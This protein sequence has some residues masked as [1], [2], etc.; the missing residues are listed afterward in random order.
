MG[1]ESRRKQWW[2]EDAER[3]NRMAEI[4]REMGA[5]IDCGEGPPPE[6]NDDGSL[7]DEVEAEDDDET[8]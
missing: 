7:A 1:V 8:E 2:R 3:V 6:L 5:V 4:A